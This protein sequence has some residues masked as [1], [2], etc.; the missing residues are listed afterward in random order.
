MFYRNC[1]ISILSDLGGCEPLYRT[2]MNG[3][4]SLERVEMAI[5]N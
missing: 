3:L 4:V 2:V 5:S 1:E